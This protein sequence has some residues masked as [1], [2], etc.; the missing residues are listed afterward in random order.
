MELG[1]DEKRIQALFSELALE[2]LTGTPGFENLW[3]RAES[4][5]PARGRRLRG[6]ILVICAALLVAVASLL[7]V[8]FWYASSS[9]DATNI[10][11][12]E[13]PTVAAPD[14]LA[15]TM[16]QPHS[17]RQRKPVGRKQSAR[18]LPTEMSLLSNWQSPTETCLQS[19]AVRLSSLPQLNQ[20]VQDLKEFLTKSNEAMKES[21]Q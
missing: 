15:W 10:A 12:Q 17:T 3:I 7:S 8:S 16:Q 9:A 5:A 21:N 13:I 2:N 6:S 1:G 20:S 14:L 4:I 19:P 18:A 11:P